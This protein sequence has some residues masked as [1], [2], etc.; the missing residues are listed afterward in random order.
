M[1]DSN[2]EPMKGNDVDD[3]PSPIVKLPQT[4]EYAQLLSKFAI[5]HPSEL[6]ILDLM[7][8]HF[9]TNRLNKVSISNINK[10]DHIQ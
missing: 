9:F 3:Q 10:R 4:L 2:K 5:E 8:M 1:L 7:N 6:S